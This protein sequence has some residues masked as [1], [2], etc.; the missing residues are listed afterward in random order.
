MSNEYDYIIIGSG[1]AGI[2]LGY[3]FEDTNKNYIILEKSNKAGS[4]FSKYPRHRKLISI[5]KVNV[6]SKSNDFKL[7]H[8]W[9]SLLSDYHNH[10]FLLKK[11]TT[12]YY[13]DANKFVKYLDSYC[14]HFNIKIKF[15]STVTKISRINNN[16]IIFVN[17]TIYKTKNLIIGTGLSKE[18]IPNI[19]GKE[20]ITTYGNMS[21]NHNK[22]KNKNISI[23]G[24][25]NSGLETANHLLGD[26]NIIHMFTR[27]PDKK[28][29]WST[30][31]PGDL[32][33]VNNAFIDSYLL[34]SQN[35]I[36]KG[37]NDNYKIKK[38]G[39]KL[40]INDENNQS[41]L[42]KKYDYII[43]CA[44]FKFDDSIF[45]TS[46]KPKIYNNVPELKCDFSSVNVPNLYFIGVLMQHTDYKK[47][48]G[49]FI[50]GFRYYIRSLFRIL[51]YEN[52]DKLWPS[53]KLNNL[54]QLK[55]FIF[56]RINNSSGMYQN[57]GYL[58]DVIKINSNSFTYYYELPIKYISKFK[59]INNQDYITIILNYGGNLKHNFFKNII[60]VDTKESHNSKFLHPIITYYN[61]HKKTEILHILEDVNT[62]WYDFNKHKLPLIQFLNRNINTTHTDK[63]NYI[64]TF[65]Y[66][67]NRKTNKI[68]ILILLVLLVIY[69]ITNS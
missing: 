47:S 5:N 45:H 54:D 41:L 16:F 67:D 48:S 23:L 62:E 22:Y 56:E 49:A 58:C 30:H 43:S 33:S 7:R 34:K 14:K 53:K 40:S 59:E 20:Y 31:Y 18:N 51:E 25:G 29:S 68:Y 11:F 26:T 10:S 27:G 61:N 69:L 2:Q 50:H 8:D 9:N 28:L 57:F 44:G 52:H 1:P 65:S 15:N 63:N 24:I 36:E 12:D 46:I 66:L 60:T 32:R 6:V 35:V 13:P 42:K 37:F 55:N 4:F 21:L 39:N 19:K 3:Y 38:I 17:D 64:E